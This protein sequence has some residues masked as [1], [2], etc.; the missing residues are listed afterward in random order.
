MQPSLNHIWNEAQGLPK[1]QRMKLVEKLIHQL[2]IED[3]INE[4][5]LTWQEMYGIGKGIWNM[6]AQEYV[7]QIREDRS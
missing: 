5:L 4:P 3:E 6:D 1:T 7:N 2:I